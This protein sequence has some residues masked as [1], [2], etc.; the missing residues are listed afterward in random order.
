MSQKSVVIFDVDDTLCF[1]TA[2]F[3]RWMAETFKCPVSDPATQGEYVLMAPFKRHTDW[4]ATTALKEFEKTEWFR[5]KMQATEHV[6]FL[7]RFIAWG[8]YDVIILTA[9]GWMADPYSDTRTWLSNQGI[10]GM[11]YELHVLGLHESKA[12]YING[13]DRDVRMILD[14]NPHHLHEISLKCKVDE[15]LVSTQAWNEHLQHGY[16][17]LSPGRPTL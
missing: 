17:H 12:D 15:I 4:D 1:F 5:E 8:K 11:D 3:N 16:T 14:D 13:L 2:G 6:D 9:R 10:S 7:K